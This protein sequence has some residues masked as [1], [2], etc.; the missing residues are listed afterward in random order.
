MP[1]GPGIVLGSRILDQVAV[2]LVEPQSA[3]N[4]GA[5]ARALHNMGLSSLVLV[6]PV[7][8]DD[9][10]ARRMA[11]GGI[12]VLRGARQVDS[13][14]E[15]IAGA[16]LTIATTRRAGKNRGPV[17]DIRDAAGRARDVAAAG[18]QV[19]LVFGR[20]DSGLTTAELDACHLLSRIPAAPDYPS[21]NLAQAVL[22][23]VY[24]L[25]RAIQVGGD[26]R[27]RRQLAT[28]RETEALFRQMASILEEIGFLNPQNPDEIMHALRRLLGRAA[29]DP[30]EVRILRGVFRQARWAAR[31]R[32]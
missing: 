31:R 12:E 11:M 17:L 4:V 15:A 20:E 21:L 28:A 22:I 5:S 14:A 23:A 10:D 29:M 19:A 32:P 27:D 6:R 3:G 2:V 26:S 7:D 16:G 13:L 18:N 25:W 8:V 24:E 30:R 9:P 1:P